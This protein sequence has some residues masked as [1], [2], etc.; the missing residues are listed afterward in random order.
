MPFFKIDIDEWQICILALIARSYS[1]S[2]FSAS[3]S[4]PSRKHHLRCASKL[5]TIFRT[6]FVPRK[7][8]SS[9]SLHPITI[10]SFPATPTLPA[11]RCCAQQHI[12]AS[13]IDSHSK[14]QWLWSSER[15]PGLLH[16]EWWADKQINMILSMTHPSASLPTAHCISCVTAILNIASRD[17]RGRNKIQQDEDE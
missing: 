4:S 3:S 2:V 6:Y 15:R 13:Y 14:F 7:S 17:S 16:L 12:Y 5:Q 8:F 10:H 9:A 11:F 1:L